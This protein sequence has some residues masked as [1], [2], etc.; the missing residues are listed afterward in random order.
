MG[1][2]KIHTCEIDCGSI[3]I[4]ASANYPAFYRNKLK[5]QTPKY[6]GVMRLRNIWVEDTFAILKREHN[7]KRINKRGILCVEEE[8][9]FV[10]MALNLKRMVKA[11]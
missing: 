5:Y 10:A 7:L 8:S 1:C 9:L 6:F 2:S 11:S 4:N 3:R